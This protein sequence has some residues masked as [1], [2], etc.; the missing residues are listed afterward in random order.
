MKPILY[1]KPGCPWC[2]SARSYFEQH[3]VD[4]DIRD[5]LSSRKDMDR[6]VEISGQTLTPTFEYGEFVVSDFS[7]DEFEQEL[8]EF[9]EVMRELGI[10]EDS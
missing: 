3:G 4:L 1:I 9:P 2:R 7:V 10:D 6:M 8:E 5:V